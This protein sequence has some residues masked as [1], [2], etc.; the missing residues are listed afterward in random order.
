MQHPLLGLE[1]LRDDTISAP[2]KSVVRSH[3]ERWDGSGYPS[4][5][6]GEEI[7]CS[8]ASPRWP[9]SSAPSRASASMRGVPRHEGVDLIPPGR[10][11][12]S[13]RQS[14]RPS[15]T[16][17]ALVE[18][19]ERGADD[20]LGV[21][22]VVAVDVVEIAGLPEA[23]DA[24]RRERHGVIPPRNASAFG[25]PSRTVTIG[26]ARSAGN[27]SSR[28]SA[29][30]SPKPARARKRAQ[31]QVGARH[32]DHVGVLAE[33]VGRAQ[34]LRHHGSHAR[35]RDRRLPLRAA[36]GSRRPARARGAPRTRRRRRAPGRA[37][38]WRA[39]SRRTR[40]RAGRGARARAAASTRGPGRMPAPRRCSPAGRSR[41]TA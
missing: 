30:C 29:G 8:R 25:S 39:G 27:S 20:R 13:I 41:S 15:S 7:R 21:D 34:Q 40:R 3:H 33:R 24:Q 14:S 22:L 35:E 6:V 10:A 23:R 16:W 19:V 32:A 17:R 37:G 31:E 26:A 11:A 5:L 38:A 4:G 18:Q 12:S 9:T 28:I 2:A 1:F 36:A